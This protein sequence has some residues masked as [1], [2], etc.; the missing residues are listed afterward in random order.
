MSRVANE[1]RLQRLVS[2]VVDPLIEYMH[3]YL[4]FFGA[5]YS[6]FSYLEDRLAPRG[7][8]WMG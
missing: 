2:V 7:D 1:R 6:I 5:L 8:V 3:D 4:R